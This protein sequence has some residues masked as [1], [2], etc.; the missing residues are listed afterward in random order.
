MAVD[1]KRTEHGDAHALTVDL[2]PAAV[3]EVDTRL[4]PA[5][6]SADTDRSGTGGIPVPTER[7]NTMNTQHTA[8][9]FLASLTT[10]LLLGTCSEGSTP[11][12]G[13]QSP[14]SAESSSAG[15][16]P[17][18]PSATGDAPDYTLLGPT[19][20]ANLAPGRW[21]VTA[22][23]SR[24]VPLAVVDLPEGLNGGG[25]YIWA[26]AEH[27]GW[28]L[29]Y[30]TVDGVYLDPCTRKGTF[31]TRKLKFPDI[32]VE[33]LAAQRR[34][35]TS[36]AVPVTLGGYDGIY[37]ELTA[38]THLDY[39]TCRGERLTIFETT[40]NGGHHWIADPGVVER[41]WVL[42]VDG[43]RV[44]LTGAVSPESTDSQIEQLERIVESVQFV[45]S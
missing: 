40:A 42:N 18:S 19:S 14:P 20:T 43:E 37:V 32:W 17:A 44:V 21:A 6:R 45:R 11:S 33:A 34:T 25:E 23:G 30:W 10:L 39:S 12:A 29:G 38:P 9:A 28:I 27:G 5:R 41:Y 22:S 16:A 31:D 13:E 3:N 36:Q 24:D 7:S 35:E 26:S 8:G 15:P 4:I 1:L 2:F